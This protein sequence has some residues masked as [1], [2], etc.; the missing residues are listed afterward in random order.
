MGVSRQAIYD[1][2][3]GRNI[4]QVNL[5][6]LN[7]LK[8]AARTIAEAGVPITPMTLARKLSGGNTLLATIAAG[9]DG[10]Q[11]AQSLIRVLSSEA[12]QQQRLAKR[13]AGR[14]TAGSPSDYG[15]PKLSE[16]A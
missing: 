13:L 1:W 2:K 5:D 10:V 6:K 8:A 15:S 7:H 11:I 3:A 9:G 12:E 14:A 4:K 16:E